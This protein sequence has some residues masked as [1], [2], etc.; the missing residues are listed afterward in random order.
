[1]RAPLCRPVFHPLSA[2]LCLGFASFLGLTG[3][4]QTSGYVMN[5][6]GKGYYAQGN[7]L[8]ARR[9]FERALM[10]SPENA[11]YAFNVAS[12]MRKQGDLI[13]AGRMYRRALA[14]DPRHQPAHHEVAALL[15]DQG[16]EDEAESH[17]EEWAATQPYV[18]EAHVEQAW[19]Q[20]QRGDLATAEQ[21]LQAALRQKPNHARAMAQLGQI[22]R[23]TGRPQQALA[24]YQRSL[25]LNPFQPEVRAQLASL[26]SGRQRGAGAYMAAY[27]PR[28]MAM[29]M[30]SSSQPPLQAA[31]FPQQVPPTYSGFP[32]QAFSGVP[33]PTYSGFAPST[34]PGLPQ[35]VMQGPVPQ[36][37]IQQ[38]GF[39]QPSMNIAYA[40]T[41]QPTGMAAPG[42]IPNADPAHMPFPMTNTPIVSPF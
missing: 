24:M 17:I 23:D 26:Q 20:R 7:Y 31:A 18:P 22:Y 13:G 33:Q 15:R 37:I 6:S 21:S 1:M 27:P 29:P 36:Q 35:P 9:E 25:S 39:V 10:D 4:N 2:V 5:E 28:G 14:L 12:A 32:Q 11:N 38:T 19:M 42:A 41:P 34:S 40:P 3:C 30:M 8:A 16:R